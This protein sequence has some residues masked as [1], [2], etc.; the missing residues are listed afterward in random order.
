MK[1]VEF[2]N[3]D[4]WR[5]REWLLKAW[6]GANLRALV[7]REGWLTREHE[8]IELGSPHSVARRLTIEF[9]VPDALRRDGLDISRAA[10]EAEHSLELA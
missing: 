6:G 1:T 8:L 4:Q 3:V 7:E 9:R 5:E 2:E 10:S